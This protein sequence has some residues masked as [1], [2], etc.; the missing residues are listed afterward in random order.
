MRIKTANH[1]IQELKILVKVGYREV[2]L[3]DDNLVGNRAVIKNLLTRIIEP[4]I[5]LFDFLPS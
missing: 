1:I 5:P 2:F 3:A 4:R